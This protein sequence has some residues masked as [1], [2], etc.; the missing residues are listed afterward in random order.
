MYRSSFFQLTRAVILGYLISAV[1]VFLLSW[2]L[3]VMKWEWAGSQL[4]IRIIYFLSCLAG[5]FL[6]G[7]EFRE[8]RLIWGILT[9]ILYA[10]ILVTVSQLTGGLGSS[11]LLEVVLVFGI[12]IGGGAA[13]SI[14][15]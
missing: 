5:G 11:G 13:G 7:R 2:G 3:Y 10:V 4:T 1:S 14:V 9:G 6:A 15:S 12:C 8:R